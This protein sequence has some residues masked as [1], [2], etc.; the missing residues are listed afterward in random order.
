MIGAATSLRAVLFDRDGT[1]IVNV[2]YNGDPAK[3]KLMPEA[4]QAVERLRFA[5][6]RIGVVSNQSG[7]ARGL[8]SAAQ[9]DAVN[10]RVD[11]F[12]GPIQAWAICPHLPQDRCDCRKPL[13]GLIFEAA[14]ALGVEPAECAVIGDVGSDMDAALAAGARGIL[15]PTRQTKPGEVQRAAEV[16]VDLQAAVDLLLGTPR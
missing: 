5:G 14:A 6:L 1:L 15:V 3:V 4:A 13:P 16:A 10:R 2:P 7:V 9:V 8:I 11:E 12:L